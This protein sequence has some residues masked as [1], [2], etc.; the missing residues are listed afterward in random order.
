[1]KAKGGQGQAGVT[2]LEGAVLRNGE[3][4]GTC[5]LQAG[6]AVLVTGAGPLELDAPLPGR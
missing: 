6:R 3:P 5:T 1:M 4:F 2:R